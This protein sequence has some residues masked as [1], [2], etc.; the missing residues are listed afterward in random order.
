MNLIT[1]RLAFGLGVTVG[2]AT[3]LAVSH[4]HD[5][6]GCILAVCTTLAS[7]V[8]GLFLALGAAAWWLAGRSNRALVLVAASLGPALFLAVAFP[9]GGPE[10]FVGS[11]FWPT[12]I[13]IGLVLAALPLEERELRIG[14]ALY[15]V[16]TI[17]AYLI[18]SPMGGNV[19]RLGG[20]FGGPLLAC[21]I[22]RRRPW[23]LA[24]LAIPLLYWQ[25]NAPVRDF[26]RAHDDPS[27]QASYYR[28]LLK[29][30]DANSGGG[31]FR[32]EIPFTSNHWESAHVAPHYPLARGWERQLDQKYNELFYDS[33]LNP[34]AYRRWIEDNAVRYVALSD[35]PLDFSAVEEDELVRNGR[36]PWLTEVFRSAHWRVFEVDG[37]PTAGRRR[38]RD[39]DG[40][41]LDRPRRGASRRPSGCACASRPTGSWRRATAASRT[42]ATGRSCGCAGPG[43]VRLDDALLARSVSCRAGPVVRVEPLD[44]MGVPCS[45]VS[46]QSPTRLFPHGPV[47]V[48]RQVAAV[49]R[50]L[51]RLPA[52]ARLDRRRPGRGGRVRERAPPDQH[53]AAHSHLFVEPNV[54]DVRP[55][56]GSS[57]RDVASWMYMN[58]QFVDHA[59]RAGVHLPVP[60]RALLLRAQHVHGRRWASRWSAT[61]SSRPRRRASSSRSGAS[62]HGRRSSPGVGHDS[63]TV[64][65]LFNPYAAVPS[66][67][68][69]FALMIGCAAARSC[70][71]PRG[72]HLL[73][74]VPLISPSCRRRPP[75]TSSPT[76]SSA[77]SPR[78]VACA[79]R[80]LARAV[81]ARGLVLLAGVP[82]AAPP[83]DD[84][85]SPRAPASWCATGSSS[86]G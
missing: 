55:A 39:E 17:A 44:R 74:G 76:P 83:P 52:D 32:V 62:G 2:L 1:G 48:L 56:A 6:L 81:A 18:A 20:L 75:T 12:I 84:A 71:A 66:M 22:W 78:A 42:T 36:L 50:C 58:A 53:R 33:E 47:D 77:P 19:V 3:V 9:E 46:G 40:R 38:D 68:V 69:C 67:H 23:V 7:P 30:L 43:D 14:C 61:R 79:R 64:N 31:P 60:Q 45:S 13:T 28:P 80:G 63:D 25:W 41:G 59:R 37:P 57:S 4:R 65:A 8:A 82:S 49:R 24:A 54:Q 26:F 15:A 5:V 16:A 51:L 27:I 70:Q 85:A 10:P 29:F 72:A 73:G 21:L 35:A 34:F 86:R 11:S